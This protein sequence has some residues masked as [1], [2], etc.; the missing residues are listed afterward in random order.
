MRRAAPRALRRLKPQRAMDSPIIR[1]KL[2]QGVRLMP[3]TKALP[4]SRPPPIVSPAAWRFSKTW[5]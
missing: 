1:P 2:I 3:P 4:E 5:E